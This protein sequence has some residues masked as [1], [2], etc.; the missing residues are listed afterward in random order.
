VVVGDAGLGF[1]ACAGEEIHEGGF[2]LG[3]AGLE[4]VADEE[5]GEGGLP[6]SLD[7]GVLGRAVDEDAVLLECG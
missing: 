5:A 2:E 3:L 7:E 1:D 4:V 6:D